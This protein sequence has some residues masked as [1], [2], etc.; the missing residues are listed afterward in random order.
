MSRA[1]DRLPTEP[2]GSPVSPSPEAVRVPS[3]PW[4]RPQRNRML[5]LRRLKWGRAAWL[6]GAIACTFSTLGFVVDLGRVTWLTPRV[7][8][9]A[10][11][12]WSGLI[13]CLYVLSIVHWRRLIPV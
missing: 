4:S 13:A 11:A 1:D 7:T 2:H 6:F 10:M 12:A 5:Y 3:A 8:V 9:I